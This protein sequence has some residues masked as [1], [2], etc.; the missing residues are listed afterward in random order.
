MIR[1]IV[2]GALASSLA[3]AL[4]LVLRAER[5]EQPR[6]AGG[7]SGEA[8]ESAGSAAE[9]TS[10]EAPLPGTTTA[11]DARIAAGPEEA[12]SAPRMRVLVRDAVNERPV[13]LSS[14]G[15][16]SSRWSRACRDPRLHPALV[17]SAFARRP[18]RR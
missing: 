2:M 3:L 14:A 9:T 11:A 6:A 5:G 8:V 12:G 16:T 1:R 13:A 18:G 17:Y 15:A 4:F 10:A 7:P